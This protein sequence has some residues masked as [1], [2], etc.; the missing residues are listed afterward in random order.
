M[1]G[2]SA[3]ACHILNDLAKQRNQRSSFDPPLKIAERFSACLE[4]QI[5]RFIVNVVGPDIGRFEAL[6]RQA[7]QQWWASAAY[8]NSQAMAFTHA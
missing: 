8:L 2:G 7:S 6:P 4:H 3:A 5:F 1:R